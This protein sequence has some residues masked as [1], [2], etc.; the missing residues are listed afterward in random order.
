MTLSDLQRRMSY[1]ELQTWVAYV[2]EN[3][4][5]NPALRIEGA[6]ARAVSPFLKNKT[7]KDLMVWPRVQEFELPPAD[8]AAQLAAKF[9]GLAS[10]TNSRKKH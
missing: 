5:L 6:I 2:D 7:P 4:P 9:K 1:Q 8:M 3:G 10:Q